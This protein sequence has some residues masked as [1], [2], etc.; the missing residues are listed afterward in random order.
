MTNQVYQ[1][2]S[3]NHRLPSVKRNSAMQSVRQ[4]SVEHQGKRNQCLSTRAPT[5]GGGTNPGTST[6]QDHSALIT[7]IMREEKNID[8]CSM[9]CEAF[10][11]PRTRAL[12]QALSPHRMQPFDLW[13]NKWAPNNHPFSFWNHPLH[14]THIHFC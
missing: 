11:M 10:I 4:P 7:F 6:F 2:P 5:T 14:A 12:P 9:L 3:V 13:L 1:P 8:L